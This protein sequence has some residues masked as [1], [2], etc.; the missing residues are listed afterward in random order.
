MTLFTKSKPAAQ[1][2][3]QPADDTAARI[4]N[5]IA[6]KMELERERLA[7]NP[8]AAERELAELEE[9]QRQREVH[10]EYLRGQAASVGTGRFDSQDKQAELNV[11]EMVVERCIAILRTIQARSNDGDKNADGALINAETALIDCSKL[12]VGMGQIH[13]FDAARK[14]GDVVAQ[15]AARE[16]ADRETA[17]LQAKRKKQEAE[18][19]AGLPRHGWLGKST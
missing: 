18:M 19:Q 1:P 14:G 13:D 8:T 16:K 7:C 17:A 15:R 6:R 5:I 10:E 3:K 12:C 11:P 2:A 4:D 9:G